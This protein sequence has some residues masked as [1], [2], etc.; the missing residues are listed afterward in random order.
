[1]SDHMCLHKMGQHTTARPRWEP[2]SVCGAEY[3]S[4][5]AKKT[6]DLAAAMRRH[7]LDAAG[8]DELV[9]QADRAHGLFGEALAQLDA[10]HPNW[11]KL[12]EAE[13][14]WTALC[15]TLDALPKGEG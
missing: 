8:L 14:A 1:M 12:D 7:N 4:W 5:H 9:E 10:H 11:P 2:C 6:D 13:E 3:K 15:R